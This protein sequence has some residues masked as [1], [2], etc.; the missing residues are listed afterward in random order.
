ML[1]LLFL[2]SVIYVAAYSC[3]HSSGQVEEVQP[4]RS[5]EDYFHEGQNK[6]KKIPKISK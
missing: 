3:M 6:I 2:C 4:I 1:E 5:F